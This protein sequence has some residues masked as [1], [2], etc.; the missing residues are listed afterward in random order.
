MGSGNKLNFALILIFLLVIATAAY[1]YNSML[2]TALSDSVDNDKQVLQEYNDEII[3]K[4][5]KSDDISQWKNIISQYNDFFITINDSANEL[6]VENRDSELSAFD[7]RAQS[8]FE[9]NGKAYLLTSSIY[10]LRE[11]E[12]NDNILLK[13]AI[14]ELV[15][16]LSAF[17]LLVFVIYTIMIRPYRAFY[18]SVE[19]Y[20]QTGQ[21]KKRKFFGY[22][23][24]VYDKFSKMTDNL[25]RQKDNQ[26]RIIASISHDIK[27]PLTSIM[28]YSEQLRKE[29]LSE[30]RRI[31]YLDK[32]YNKSIEIRELVDEFD[33]YLSYDMSKNMSTEKVSTSALCS[34]V[35]DECSDELENIGVALQINNYAP[36]A[37]M[38][39]DISK[40]RR[41]FGNIISNSIKHFK[42]GE[43]I[44][45]IDVSE[46]NDVIQINISDNGYGVEADKLEMI[47]EPLYTS[48]KGR[49]VAGLGLAIC[50]EI[51]ENHGGN[52]HAERSDMGGLK[53]CIE[54]KK[55]R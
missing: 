41:V 49:K 40:M 55:R 10:L 32:L 44:I 31:R 20:E 16:I 43:K 37:S 36:K 2:T 3:R 5:T 26:R 15:I 21:F 47:F 53:V 48:D 28:G 6:V 35:V 51:V 34:T 52:I 13:V 50:R 22:I 27:T 54:L 42:D 11:Y 14:I 30:E 4:L 19:D 33:E 12:V 39:L 45:R 9:Y 17:C 25:E 38:M 7:I 46:H 23:G 1:S 24:R 18:Q 29:S 8:A